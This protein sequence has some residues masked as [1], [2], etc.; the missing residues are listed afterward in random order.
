MYVRARALFRTPW[1]D[2]RNWFF[3]AIDPDN[4]DQKFVRKCVCARVRARVSVAYV[5]VHV[6]MRVCYCCRL[7][8]S[9][10]CVNACDVICIRA[11]CMCLC[12]CICVRDGDVHGH[13]RCAFQIE[14]VAANNLT[15]PL[16][17]TPLN[18]RN[19]EFGTL[20]RKSGPHPRPAHPRTTHNS[21]RNTTCVTVRGSVLFFP[22]FNLHD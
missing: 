1:E 21:A 10:P 18:N 22:S 4:R 6:C 3:A 8:L 16:A 7:C 17:G 2:P 5:R 15:T 11:V 9:F 14:V 12:M 19:I 13:S 20:H